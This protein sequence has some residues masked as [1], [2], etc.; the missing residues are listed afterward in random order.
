M[1][2]NIQPSLVV[3]LDPKNLG[4]AVVIS[5]L[6]YIQVEIYVTACV[7]PVEGGHVWFTSHFD[8]K[9]DPTLPHCVPQKCWYPLEIWFVSYSNYDMLITS[10]VIAAIVNFFE[11]GPKY[12]RYSRHHKK[13]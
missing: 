2:E 1:S 10:G 8:V 5:L 4:V 9:E 11:R 12:F 3:L 6:S 7:L 13:C